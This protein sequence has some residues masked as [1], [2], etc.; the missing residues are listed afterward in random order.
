[1]S[2]GGVRNMPRRSK[3][4]IGS[5]RQRATRLVLPVMV[6]AMLIATKG[7]IS[8]QQPQ[9]DTAQ[10]DQILTT[11]DL[12]EKNVTVGPDGAVAP[13]TV[14][15]GRYLVN[16]SAPAHRHHPGRS[17]VDGAWEVDDFE[18]LVA[19][20]A[21]YEIEVTGPPIGVDGEVG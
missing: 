13:S 21:R 9:N 18:R 17:Y 7:S 16:L 14:S 12:H 5:I 19:V 10:S 1:M 20:A 4:I 8:A 3:V 11:L 2:C 6:I 15:A